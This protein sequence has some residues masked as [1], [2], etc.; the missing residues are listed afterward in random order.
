[1]LLR[2]YEILEV[3]NMRH[4]V[5]INNKDYISLCSLTDIVQRTRKIDHL[6]RTFT[7]RKIGMTT[8]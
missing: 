4:G 3:D 2:E 6:E 8:Q 1:M 5:N 7:Y